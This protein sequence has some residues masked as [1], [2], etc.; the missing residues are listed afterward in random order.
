MT[1]IIQHRIVRICYNDRDLSEQLKELFLPSI[2][3][4]TFPHD[5]LQSR[6]LPLQF[7]SPR[8]SLLILFL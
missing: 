6:I 8:K 3:N 7:L 4:P 1:Y 2:R 5:L